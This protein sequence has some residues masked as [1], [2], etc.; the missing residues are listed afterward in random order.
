MIVQWRIPLFG[1]LLAKHN[2]WLTELKKQ[3][4]LHAKIIMLGMN[5]AVRGVH[6]PS[7]SDLSTETN[8]IYVYVQ[9][10]G[11]QLYAPL[12]KGRAGNN[13]KS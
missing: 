3:A 7:L 6:E 1:M 12:M 5:L 4:A 13:K 10:Y 8:P 11:S 2:C 9:R